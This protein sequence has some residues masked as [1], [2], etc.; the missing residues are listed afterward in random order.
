MLILGKV[1]EIIQKHVLIFPKNFS[2]FRVKKGSKTKKNVINDSADIFIVG[3]V[4][5]KVV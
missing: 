1:R 2:G 3:W 5:E 4:K